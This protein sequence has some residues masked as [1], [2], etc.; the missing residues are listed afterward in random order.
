M[1]ISLRSDISSIEIT[2]SIL[3]SFYIMNP[4]LT[5]IFLV[6]NIVKG[7]CFLK[8]IEYMVFRTEEFVEKNAFMCLVL[9]LLTIF[10]PICLFRISSTIFLIPTSVFRKMLR[11]KICNAPFKGSSHGLLAV[12]V[13]PEGRS[14]KAYA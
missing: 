2:G 5:F 9:Y 14:S 4:V 12:E 6:G 3:T 10:L 8:R 11:I 13:E 1:S 7:I